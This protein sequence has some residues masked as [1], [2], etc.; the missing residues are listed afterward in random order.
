MVR[1]IFFF[2]FFLLAGGG[3][4]GLCLIR[5]A[6]LSRLELE[7]PTVPTSATKDER[8]KG[9][10]KRTDSDAESDRVHVE[11]YHARVRFFR[12]G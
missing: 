5:C 2:F 12:L 11:L 9:M 7:H 6:P 8:K 1:P 10:R 3:G 4:G